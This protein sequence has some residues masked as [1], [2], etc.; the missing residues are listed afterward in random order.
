[1]L[2]VIVRL[3]KNSDFVSKNRVSEDHTIKDR[4]TQPGYFSRAMGVGLFLYVDKVPI[5]G[6]GGCHVLYPN[7]NVGISQ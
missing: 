1:M 7:R 3:S 4:L 2:S 6:T 5:L